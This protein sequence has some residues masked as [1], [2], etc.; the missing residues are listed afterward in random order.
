MRNFVSLPG[1]ASV[2]AVLLLAACAAMDGRGLV[3]GKS[4]AAEVQ[5]VM[6]SPVQ[7]LKRPDGVEALYFARHPEGRF[8]YVVSIGPDGVMRGMEQRLARAQFARI[9]VDKT[10]AAEV[11]ELLGPPSHVMHQRLKAMDV[12]EYPWREID[13]VRVLFVGLSG[14]GIVREVRETH[15]YAAERAS[16]SD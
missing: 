14:D 2:G 16:P 10:T 15:D 6:G 5:A 4:T 13:E 11:R 1:I 12:W 9:I 8:C 3:P 7:R